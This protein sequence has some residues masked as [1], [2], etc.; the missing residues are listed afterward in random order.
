MLCAYIHKNNARHT[1]TQTDTHTACTS[2]K[3]TN[4]YLAHVQV[5]AR[6]HTQA[7]TLCKRLH[8]HIYTCCIYIHT[9]THIHTYIYTISHAYKHTAYACMRTHVYM[10]SR[11]C[12]RYIYTF[13]SN[14]IMS[15]FKNA[16]KICLAGCHRVFIQFKKADIGLTNYMENWLSNRHFGKAICCSE[17]EST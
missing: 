10:H 2:Y 11:K 3:L 4:V 14:S 8:T 1:Q 5:G 7:S 6:T 9:L 16:I 17:K 15:W 12:N 13:V